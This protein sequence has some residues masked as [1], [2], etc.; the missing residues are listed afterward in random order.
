MKRNTSGGF[1]LLELLVVV[2][3]IGLLL[4]IVMYSVSDS[5]MKGRD[6]GR[7]SQIQEI[8][9]ALELYY[10]D[11]GAYPNDG[12]PGDSS[13][14][15]FL[16]DIDSSFWGSNT[17]LNRLPDEADSRYFYCVSADRN[18]AMIAVNTEQDF[19]GTGSNF[20]HITRGVGPDFGCGV[21]LTNNA[22]DNCAIRF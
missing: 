5:R 18:S 16:S 22:T 17:Y 11:N 20:C 13:S 21:W 19:G 15:D 3:I 1:T 14:G 2:A 9:K 10:S 7:K 12:T 4:A 8:L 6:A